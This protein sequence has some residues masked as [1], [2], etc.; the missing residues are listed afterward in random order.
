[1]NASLIGYLLSAAIRNG[2]PDTLVERLV[3]SV[4]TARSLASLDAKRAET[5]VALAGLLAQVASIAEAAEPSWSL[6]GDAER[7]RWYR[8]RVL[9][10][11]ASKARAQRR[12]RAFAVLRSEAK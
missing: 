7:E 12:E 1:V 5:H 9:T 6:A 10:Q 2:W 8:D 3:A 4:A 11:V